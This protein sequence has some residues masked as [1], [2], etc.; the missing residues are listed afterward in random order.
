MEMIENMSKMSKKHFMTYSF[1]CTVDGVSHI[2]VEQHIRNISY[3][4]V[5]QV[6]DAIMYFFLIWLYFLY[7][8]FVIVL[9]TNCVFL[10]KHFI[11]N[12]IELERGVVLNADLSP[13]NLVFFDTLPKLLW[14]PLV[15]SKFDNYKEFRVDLE[16]R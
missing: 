8:L 3:S 7:G 14:A 16:K 13:D 11:N 15:A 2:V 12:A 1:P 6:Q 5:G 4:S 10:Y 9:K